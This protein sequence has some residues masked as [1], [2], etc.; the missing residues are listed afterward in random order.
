MRRSS[1]RGVGLIDA[2]IALAILSFGLLALTRF[3]GRLTAQ[4]TDAQSRAIANRLADELMGTAL[5]DLPA[6]LA[7]YSFPAAGACGNAT[8]R[9][10]TTAWAARVLTS[11]PGAQAATATVNGTRFT[12]VLGWRSKDTD[13]VRQLTAVTDVQ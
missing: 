4:A 13:E 7:C 10:N 8:A 6:N 1:A 12:V 11:L 2:L 5:V 9:A 3:Q